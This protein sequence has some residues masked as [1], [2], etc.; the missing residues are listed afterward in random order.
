VRTGYGLELEKTGDPRLAAAI[1]VD[2]MAAAADWILAQ[3]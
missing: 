3:P 2:D 1:V